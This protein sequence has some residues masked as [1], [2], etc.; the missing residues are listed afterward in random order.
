MVT[1]DL[2]NTVAFGGAVLFVGLGAFFIDFANAVIITLCVNPW[3]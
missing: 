2:I 1:L 3:T